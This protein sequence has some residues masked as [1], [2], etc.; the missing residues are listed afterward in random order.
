MHLNPA[1]ALKTP[2][3]SERARAETE[4]VRGDKTGPRHNRG[5][6]EVNETAARKAPVRSDNGLERH[7]L[8]DLLSQAPAG[9]GLLSGPDH[10]WTYV[11]EQY[12]RVTGREGAADFVG[13][14]LRES[15]P[16]IE[17][18]GFIE[19]MDKVYRT[20]ESHTGRE[21]KA[22]L[23]RAMGGPPEDLYFDFVYQPV[24][25]ANGTVEGILVHCVDVTDRVEARWAIEETAERLRLAQTAAQIGT[26]PLAGA[27]SDFRH[28]RDGSR[29]RRGLVVTG[30]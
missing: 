24:R 29:S 14:T 21:V 16:E 13:K 10:R 22:T 15:L 25:D 30:A 1:D 2:A 20:G 18:Q 28:G 4:V 8:E 3:G 11:N 12:V 5:L 7:R 17:A 9:I 26:C 23:N 6:D 19:L 27:A